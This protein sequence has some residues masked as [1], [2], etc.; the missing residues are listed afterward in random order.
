MDG[1]H[2]IHPSLLLL[3]GPVRGVQY[4]SVLIVLFVL[5]ICNK[6]M[7]P[8]VHLR[9]KRVNYLLLAAAFLAFKAATASALV[10][11]T[12]AEGLDIVI[13]AAEYSVL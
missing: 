12:A 7:H 8:K 11:A 10:G 1:F 9:K 5:L 3:L 13:L 6:K 2:G 4:T